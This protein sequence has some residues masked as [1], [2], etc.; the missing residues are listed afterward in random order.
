MQAK[1]F[2]EDFVER[3]RQ[4]YVVER[5]KDGV[6]GARMDVALVNDVRPLCR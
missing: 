5:V 1:L 3:V 2:Y 4:D 6:F